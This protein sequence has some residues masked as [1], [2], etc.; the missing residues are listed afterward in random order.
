MFNCPDTTARLYCGKV[1]A[2][3]VNKGFKILAVCSE[4]PDEKDHPKVVKLRSAL[5]SFLT[6]CLDVIQTRDC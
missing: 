5:E 4:K 1:V 3:V 2:N 6:L